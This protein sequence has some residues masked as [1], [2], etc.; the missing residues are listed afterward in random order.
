MTPDTLQLYKL[1]ILY[2]LEQAGQP[3]PNAILSDFILQHGYTNYLSIQQTL[4][5]LQE[6]Q[7]I[8]GEQ[9]HRVS[10]YTLAPLGQ[11]T[12]D[13]FASQLPSDT[14]RQITDYLKENQ[15]AIARATSVKTDYSCIRPGEYL[16]TGTL[17]ERGSKSMEVTLNVPEE[18]DAVQICRRF[19]EKNDQV[20][21]ALLRILT[22]D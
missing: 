15:I 9:T 6:D 14:R 8:Q 11:E 2:F 22:N 13:F 17:F 21:A 7:M 4:A 12:L 10:Y 1:I 19:E 5:E 3:M 16:V 18:K 20:Y